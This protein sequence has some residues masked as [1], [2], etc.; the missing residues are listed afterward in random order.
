MTRGSY[1]MGAGYVLER[2]GIPILVLH[3]PA[4]FEFSDEQKHKLRVDIVLALNSHDRLVDLTQ[5]A[6][7]PK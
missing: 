2:D 7:E 1:T 4:W 6:K 3:S 5:S